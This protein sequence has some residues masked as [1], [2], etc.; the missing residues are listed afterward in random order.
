MELKRFDDI[1]ELDR[2]AAQ[3]FADTIKHNP[4]ATL[5]LATGSTPIGIY[6]KMI[7][8]YNNGEVSFK[9]ATTFN[10]DEYVGLSPNHEQSYAQFMKHHLFDHIDLPKQQAHLPSGMVSDLNAECLSYDRML[11]EQP[12]DVQ[13]L[14]LGHNGHIGFNEPD[15]ELHGGTHVVELEEAT[16]AANA[17]FFDTP[18]EVPTKA[19]TMGVGSILK[20]D[21]IVLVVKG[22]DK[23]N[24]VKQALHGPITT[25]VPASLLQT[26]KKVIVLV[27]REAG[28][29]L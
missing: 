22:A 16:R 5:G 24:I 7:E 1:S 19:I 12:I 25:E 26:H 3:I 18:D 27:D 6:G 14:G 9:D 21:S 15:Q 17:R 20:A 4:H 28:R 23:A 2:Y 8:M 29:L 13:L 10:L 11:S